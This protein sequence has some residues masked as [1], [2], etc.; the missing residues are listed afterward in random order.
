MV[1]SQTMTSITDPAAGRPDVLCGLVP[2][3]VPQR[4]RNIFLVSARTSVR[5]GIQFAPDLVRCVSIDCL[6]VTVRS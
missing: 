3:M 4:S 5:A 6:S 1:Y 2:I